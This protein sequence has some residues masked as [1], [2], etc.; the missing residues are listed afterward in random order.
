MNNNWYIVELLRNASIGSEMLNISVTN[1]EIIAP[2]GQFQC[3]P[4]TVFSDL[5]KHNYEFYIYENNLVVK[6]KE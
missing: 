1:V 2:I 5:K 4:F 3:V 6:T